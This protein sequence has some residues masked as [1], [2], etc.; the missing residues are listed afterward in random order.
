M[1]GPAVYGLAAATVVV[2]GLNWPIMATGVDL[3]PPL[4]LAAFRMTGASV[5]VGAASAVTHGLRAPD[6]ADHPILLSVGLGRLAVVTTLV[7]TALRFVPPGRSSILVYTASLWTPPLAIAFLRE[8]LTLLR[9]AGLSCGGLGLVFLLE[10]WTFDR[11]DARLLVGVAM[12]LTAALVTAATTVHIKGHRWS[13]RPL[14][15][16]PWQLALAAVPITFLAASV[17]GAP[18]V[19]WTLGTAGIVVYQVLLGSAFGFWGLLTISRSLPAMTTT[20]TL[21]AVPVVG[22]GSILL[23]HE[24]PTLSLGLGLLLILVGVT[25]GTLSD[26]AAS[27]AVT[28]A[29]QP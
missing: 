22:L 25:F 24:R 8:R 6:R 17:E 20:L 21:M 14:E 26:R 4:W 16:M 7:F 1:R 13:G 11:S 19:R 9:V 10:P 15:L 3:I 12:L 23:V 18:D 29:P 28:S 5:V 27:E 2:L